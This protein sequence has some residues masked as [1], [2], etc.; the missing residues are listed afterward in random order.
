MAIQKS[1]EKANEISGIMIK[2]VF[3]VAIIPFFIGISSD[4]IGSQV[5][6]VL[7]VISATLY[8]FYASFALKLKS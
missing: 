7:V 1:P 6:A 3:G 4:L 5:G 2:G 8:L